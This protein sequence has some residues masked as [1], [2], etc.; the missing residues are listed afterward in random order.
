MK[1]MPIGLGEQ[2]Y[3]WSGEYIIYR[4]KDSGKDTKALTIDDYK[5]TNR[6]G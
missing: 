4:L 3:T 5:L 6:N 2:M 1:D